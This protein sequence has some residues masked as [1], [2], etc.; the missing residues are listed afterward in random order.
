MSGVLAKFFCKVHSFNL[1][2]ELFLYVPS[3]AIPG[4]AHH[5]HALGVCCAYYECQTLEPMLCLWVLR[6][7]WLGFPCNSHWH[8]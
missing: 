3:F 2:N 5:H 4:V 6:G 1:L 7:A 8:A